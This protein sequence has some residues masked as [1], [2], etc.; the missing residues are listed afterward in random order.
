MRGGGGL[1]RDPSLCGKMSSSSYKIIV[2][3]F[4]IFRHYYE[5]FDAGGRGEC[6]MCR[7]S[8]Q[9]EALSQQSMLKDDDPIYFA[10]KCDLS[11]HNII[12]LTRE[13]N[14]QYGWVR[15]FKSQIC[16]AGQI[17]KFACRSSM[18]VLVISGFTFQCKYVYVYEYSEY[19]ISKITSTNLFILFGNFITPSS[20]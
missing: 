14:F 16:L 13:L 18:V 4:H 11:Q 8:L 20:F 7:K 5:G 17:L 2:N 15:V 10:C 9:E 6:V 19:L 12:K 1:S 3:L